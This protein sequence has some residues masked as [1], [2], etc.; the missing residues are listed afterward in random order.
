[1]RSSGFQRETRS[2][3]CLDSKLVISFYFCSG[4][5]SPSSYTPC[6]CPSVKLIKPDLNTEVFTGERWLGSAWRKGCAS[7]FKCLCSLSRKL[8]QWESYTWKKA[9]NFSTKKNP[10]LL[11]YHLYNKMWKILWRLHLSVLTE[12]YLKRKS[13][14][15]AWIFKRLVRFQSKWGKQH[16]LYHS[17]LHKY[18]IK[19]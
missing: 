1:M 6:S 10:N 4:S 5:G 2:H 11:Y 8:W 9:V 3:V 13:I 16:S 7:R 15:K 14:S 12:P 19:S 18:H 17:E